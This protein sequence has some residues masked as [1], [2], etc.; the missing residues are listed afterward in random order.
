MGRACR[1]CDGMHVVLEVECS[2]EDKL[3][4]VKATDAGDKDAMLA[5]LEKW[6]KSSGKSVA[7]GEESEL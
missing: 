4:T 2:V 7:F 5:A 1:A 3:V 6:S